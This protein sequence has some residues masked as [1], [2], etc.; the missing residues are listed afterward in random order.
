MSR[1]ASVPDR[2][3]LRPRLFS[4]VASGIIFDFT[5]VKMKGSAVGV[6]KG[7]VAGIGVAADAAGSGEAGV[8][9]SIG[10]E[11]N[12]KVGVRARVRQ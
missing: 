12:A 2:S 11:F 9:A 3:V 1:A 6:G 7:T 8:M 5:F 10:V 4:C